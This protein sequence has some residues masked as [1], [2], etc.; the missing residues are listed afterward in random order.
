MIGWEPDIWNAM[1]QKLGV[2]LEVSSIAFAG[3]IPG[4]QSGRFDMAM[5]CMADTVEREEVVTFIN[6]AFIIAGVVTLEDNVRITDDPLSL[7]GLKVGG[8]EGTTHID[9]VNNLLNPHCAAN[10]KPVVEVVNFPSGGV[11]KTL[12]PHGLTEASLHVILSFSICTPI[13]SN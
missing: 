5:E 3:L 8:Q 9:N 13:S 12:L 1:A 7:C 11:R 10:G 2:E 6:V 4:V